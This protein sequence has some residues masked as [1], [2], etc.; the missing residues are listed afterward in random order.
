[1]DTQS[2]HSEDWKP[3]QNKKARQNKRGS[4]LFRDLARAMDDGH[5]AILRSMREDGLNARC[6]LEQRR[7]HFKR[8]GGNNKR[9]C[10]DDVEDDDANDDDDDDDDDGHSFKTTDKKPEAVGASPNKPPENTDSSVDSFSVAG[11]T[12]PPPL[13]PLGSTELLTDSDMHRR[14]SLH[15]QDCGG[16]GDVELAAAAAAAAADGAGGIS[17]SAAG[18]GGG[19]GDPRSRSLEQLLLEKARRKAKAEQLAM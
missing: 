11:S 19:R 7:K 8:C 10:I 2:Q 18:Q 15:G 17:S 14:W 16:S 3:A 5:E 13:K 12:S 6:Y 4:Q 1:M 9:D